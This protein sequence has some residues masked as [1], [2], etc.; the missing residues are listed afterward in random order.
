M[1]GDKRNEE[2]NILLE[3]FKNGDKHAFDEIYR[4]CYWHITFVCSKLCDNKEDIEEIVQDTFVAAFKKAKELK[5]DTFLA[6]LRKIAARR[7]YDK[8]KSKKTQSEHVIYSEDTVEPTELDENF[9][10]EEYLQNKE[11]HTE[12]LQIINSLPP[13]QR[14]IVYLYYYVDLNTV[15]IAKMQNCPSVNVRKTL[16]TARNTIK[17]RIEHQTN[18]KPIQRMASVS[19]AAV[20]LIEEELYVTEYIVAGIVGSGSTLG[21]AAAGTAITVSSVATI[22]A[23]IATV[24]VISVGAYLALQPNAPEY[25]TPE[26]VVAIYTTVTQ[27]GLEDT[28]EEVDFLEQEEPLEEEPFEERLPEEHPLNIPPEPEYEGITA[29]EVLLPP[30]NIEQ[31]ID[32][33]GY[34]ESASGYY[35][36]ETYNAPDE[37]IPEEV[38]PPLEE[39]PPERDE[40]YEPDPDHTDRTPEILRMLANATN[41]S[42]TMR[43]ISYYGFDLVTQMQ[44][45]SD[46][47]YWFYAI[48][49]GSG[50]ILIG[51]AAY[52][53]GSQWR[54]QFNHYSN[55]HRPSDRLD[56]FHWM[57]RA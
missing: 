47:R 46:K 51:I 56:L 21:T 9:L 4:R 31:H 17:N 28:E 39:D 38:P 5:A 2:L 19:L 37:E 34:V 18:Q 27:D 49:E 55:G 11:L 40:S 29:Y 35:I 7:C 14:E 13:K 53:D 44:S 20:L 50:D 23:C 24:G 26:P 48:N 3:Q 36:E 43:I 25:A 6:L 45:S 22:A 30:A 1:S 15:E 8:Y 12:L 42:D 33:A 52:E 16:H 54:M 10:P 41:N 32:Y 57:D